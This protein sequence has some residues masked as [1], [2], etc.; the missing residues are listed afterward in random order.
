VVPERN[1]LQRKKYHKERKGLKAN[2][3]ENCHS[4]DAPTEQGEPDERDFQIHFTSKCA[5]RNSRKRRV[6]GGDDGA[7]GRNDP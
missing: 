4:G 3:V 1:Y 7:S 5:G 6:G 2:V